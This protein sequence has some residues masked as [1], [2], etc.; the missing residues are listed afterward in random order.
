MR[1]VPGQPG[2]ERSG[3]SNQRT[4][5][6]TQMP[7]QKQATDSTAAVKLEKQ[8]AV[9]CQSQSVCRS[10]IASDLSPLGN[11]RPKRPAAATAVHEVRRSFQRVKCHCTTGTPGHWVTKTLLL[12]PGCCHFST[13]AWN[14]QQQSGVSIHN[15]C[16]MVE[17]GKSLM[18]RPHRLCQLS[19]VEH[20]KKPHEGTDG[21]NDR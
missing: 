4:K 20:S 19:D 21:L 15:E 6:S 2:D 13:A 9:S 1:F 14:L 12:M 11:I 18:W 10:A 5:P 16:S 8:L 17:K 3:L 7:A